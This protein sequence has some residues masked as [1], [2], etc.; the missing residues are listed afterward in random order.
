M[1]A[2][3]VETQKYF[4][5]PAILAYR[6][7]LSVLKIL[8]SIIRMRVIEPFSLRTSLSADKLRTLAYSPVP[9]NSG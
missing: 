1:D 5:A 4:F 7:V 6:M 3:S 2:L 9:P 8:T